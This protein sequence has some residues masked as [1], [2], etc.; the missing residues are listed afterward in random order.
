MYN[1][2]PLL[3]AAAAWA[4]LAS[5][6]VILENPKPFRF[7]Q[8]GPTNPISPSGSDFPCKIPQGA[9]L[10]PQGAPTV[11]VVGQQQSASFLGQAV[12]GGGSCQ[13]SLSGPVSNGS[14]E[15]YP[16]KDARWKVIHSI[17]GGCPARHQKGNLEGLNQDKYPFTILEGIEPGDYIF[18]WTWLP[19]IGGQPEYYQNCAPVTVQARPKMS[20][21]R[22][23]RLSKRAEFPELFMANMGEEVAGGCT[24]EE[25]LGEQLAIAFPNPGPSVDHPEGTQNLF[26]Q[27][28]DGN[29]RAGQG[30]AQGPG[31]SD[32]A[33]T[34]PAAP[35][36]SQTAM[37]QDGSSASSTPPTAP[38]TSAASSSPSTGP[39]LAPTSSADPGQPDGPGACLVAPG[40]KCRPGAGVGLDISPA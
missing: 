11:M 7:V 15:S 17:E 34:S 25:A 33:P 5:S 14:W 37:P 36:T 26:R 2:V 35:Q 9:T 32:S 27:Q 8:Y 12:H 24:T 20:L 28:C 13:F 29:P 6:H 10:Q 19:R 22:R 3:A 30:Q 40:F 39:T 31:S 38:T 4:S 21:G 18:S 1:S 23:A 16:L